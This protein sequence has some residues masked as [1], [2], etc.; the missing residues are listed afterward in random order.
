MIVKDSSLIYAITYNESTRVLQVTF[1]S[2]S[3]W[4][5]EEFPDTEYYNLLHAKSMGSYFMK[6]IRGKYTENEI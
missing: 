2:G 4:E 3:T 5:Y 1:H 6:N